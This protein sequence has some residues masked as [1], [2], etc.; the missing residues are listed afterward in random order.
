VFSPDGMQLASASA[1]GTIKVWDSR[2]DPEARK[3]EGRHIAFRPDGKRFASTSWHWDSDFAFKLWDTT[4]GQV[5]RT[6]VGQEGTRHTGT[7][8]DVAFSPDGKWIVSGSRDGTVK[9]WDA[10]DG[11]VLHTFKNRGHAGDINCV[12]FSPDGKLIASAGDDVTIRLW[13][14]QTGQL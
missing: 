14:V 11:Q 9:L 8:V 2:S 1:D 10:A 7:V 6:F 4:T 3:F 5:I 12:A 13:D